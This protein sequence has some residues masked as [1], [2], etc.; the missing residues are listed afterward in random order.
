MTGRT[1]DEQ[2]IV[3][4][5]YNFVQLALN[6][7]FSNPFWYDNP[8]HPPLSHCI[9]GI[10]SAADFLRFDK[11]A[12]ISFHSTP[13]GAWIF[14]YDLTFSRLLSVLFSSLSVVVVFLIGARFI[15]LFVGIVAALILATLPH[16][17]GYSQLVTHESLITFFF[18]ASAFYY[19]LYFNKKT[20]LLLIGS[21]ILTGIALESK[22]SNVLLFILLFG[23]Y[24]ISNRLYPK[25]KTVSLYHIL[26]ISLIALLT[27]V[28]LWPMPM[29]HLPELV[30]FTKDMWFNNSERVPTILF[31]TDQP[32]PFLFYLVAFLVTTPVVI[33]VLLVFGIWKVV[34]SRTWVLVALLFLFMVPFLLSVFHHR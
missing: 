32:A 27:Y 15:S 26:V 3:E 12:I 8:D 5:G 22:Q 31:G 21:G 1:W 16:F 6:M 18:T 4:K 19:L 28:L 30:S 7:D 23:L 11:N 29:F 33:L 9:Y 14:T 24:I 2:N 10:A 17:L 34:R 13:Y 25:N 20:T